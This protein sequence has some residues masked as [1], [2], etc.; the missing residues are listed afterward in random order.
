MDYDWWY[1]LCQVSVS[2]SGNVVKDAIVRNWEI[3]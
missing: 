3:F 1:V 2:V